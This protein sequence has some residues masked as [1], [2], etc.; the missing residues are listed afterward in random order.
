MRFCRLRAGAADALEAKKN[1][2]SSK[3]SM[4]SKAAA[5]ASIDLSIGRHTPGLG[6]NVEV[7]FSTGRYF[8]RVIKVGKGKANGAFTVHFD[9][10]QTTV[11]IVPGEHI[12]RTIAPA[13]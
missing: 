1:N 6:C 2:R 12:Y 13:S 4:G 9:V 3:K 8:G 11:E 10:D 7:Q 5:K